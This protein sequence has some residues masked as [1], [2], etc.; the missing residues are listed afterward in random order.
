MSLD[1]RDK[2]II[3]IILSIVGLICMLLIICFIIWFIIR[4]YR[5]KTK[6]MNSNE[7][8]NS[9]PISSYHRQQYQ[10]TQR[11]P[12]IKLNHNNNN[13]IN[14]KRK[15]KKRRFNTNDSAL[16]LSF[17]PPHLIN[18]NVKNLDKLLTSESTLTANSWHYEETLPKKH[19]YYKNPSNEPVYASS[20]TV[21]TTVS[22][23]TGT[24][25]NL[26]NV[27]YRFLNELDHVLRL[28]QEE[29]RKHSLKYT[30]SCRQT[31]D[32]LPFDYYRSIS[33]PSTIIETNSS[34]Q[35]SLEPIYI[36]TNKFSNLTLIRKA[37][38]AQLRDDTAI[39]Y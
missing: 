24:H 14:K 7:E 17:D 33:P 25:E 8:N 22:N 28:K 19:C 11:F 13:I 31:T 27:H 30:Q 21:L 35:N 26:N 23:L 2:I 18:Q 39:L 4:Y 16:T 34:N 3:T 36:R 1:A 5:L 12:S 9:P 29:R 6:R 32:L 38:L 10:R 37:R 20:S 15:R